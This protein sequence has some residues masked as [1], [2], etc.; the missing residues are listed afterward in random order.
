VKHLMIFLL[1]F[2]ISIARA[3]EPSIALEHAT[4]N[5]HDKAS[6]KR[7]AKFF[8]TVCMACHTLVYLRYDKLALEAGITY[9]K[10]P[11]NVKTWPLDIRPPDLSLEVDYRGADWIY[12]Y[13]HSFYVDPSRPFGVNNVLVPGTAMAGIITAYQGQQILVKDLKGSQK[14]FAHQYQW[15]DL[16]ELQSQG[17]M[18]PQQFDATVTDV[19]NFLAYAA[20]PYQLRQHG[21]GYWVI[22]FLFILAVLMYLLKKEYWKD[23]KK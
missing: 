16:L 18:T 10:M 3:D 14:F 13:L 22:G 21:L 12:T 8:A 11:I 2:S 20:A 7:G 9:E 1:F 4:V 15:Y 6:I 23:V 19:I 5:L 17:S